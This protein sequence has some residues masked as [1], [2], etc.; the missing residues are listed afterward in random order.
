M[1]HIYCARKFDAR[2]CVARVTHTARGT[3]CCVSKEW[4]KKF[5]S[6]ESG[7]YEWRSYTVSEKYT[8]QKD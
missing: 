2:V 7:W 4:Y 1:S 8:E 6:D 5:S 3:T